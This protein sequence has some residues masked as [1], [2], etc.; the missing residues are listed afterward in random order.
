MY[1]NRLKIDDPIDASV[2]HLGGGLWG[3]LSVGLFADI[4]LINA[5]YG[6]D[7]IHGGLFMGVSFFSLL[8][9]HLLTCVYSKV[10]NNWLFRSS[11]PL[12]LSAGELLG[13]L[14]CGSS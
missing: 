11:K 10:V 6:K 12:L 8:F 14:V 4:P 2:V 7:T 1:Q 3:V 13:P 9:I 5:A